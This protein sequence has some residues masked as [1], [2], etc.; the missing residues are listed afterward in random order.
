[1][2]KIKNKNKFTT[3][4]CACL[5]AIGS[6]FGF[7]GAI[8]NTLA[9]TP[10]KFTTSDLDYSISK[11]NSNYD[12]K[13]YFDGYFTYGFASEFNLYGFNT[14]PN[15]SYEY[16]ENDGGLHF[17]IIFNAP[18]TSSRPVI[19]SNTSSYFSGIA[20][21]EYIEYFTQSGSNY[22]RCAGAFGGLNGVTANLISI[23]LNKI[24]GYNS[25]ITLYVNGQYYNFCSMYMLK[26][27][28]SYLSAFDTNA[29]EEGYNQGLTEGA[30]V[31][32]DNPNE[33]DLFTE[34]QYNDNYNNGFNNGISYALYGIFS[35]IDYT[36]TQ[37]QGN[38]VL[39]SALLPYLNGYVLNPD[40]YGNVG[41]ITSSNVIF[42]IN[43]NKPFEFNNQLRFTNS[44]VPQYYLEFTLVDTNNNSYQ[45]YYNK[46]TEYIFDT[47]NN[48]IDTVVTEIIE[49]L[50]DI[51]GNYVTGP[52]P[53]GVL[54]KN[55]NFYFR[56][57]YVNKVDL[58]LHQNS[59]DYEN[60]YTVGYEQGFNNGVGS[61]DTSNIYDT[62][63]NQGFNVGKQIGKSEGIASANDYSFISLFGALFDV[64]VKTLTGL[65]N[66]DLLG[67]NLF[68]FF[69]SLLTL[70]LVIWL[71][72]KFI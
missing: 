20:N 55:L 28:E 45:Y 56:D 10:S 70:S 24:I 60:G 36:V 43:F 9:Y 40:Y 23:A 34:S 25:V 41:S 35:D 68:N 67:F 8:G 6:L 57:S 37:S 42:D 12:L 64:P 31:V 13:N 27:N 72:T 44:F 66:F 62:A 18:V 16:Y 52:V 2:I 38:T 53:A 39:D 50:F 51:N 54:I 29:Y 22:I 5:M 4:L 3:F 69:T 15:V 61:V 48:L 58:F 26:Q 7:V 65:L 33:Y 49:P 17:D 32:L 47:D 11:I 46:Q 63:Y 59:A 19:T 21:I 14:L 30:D 1:M 71:I